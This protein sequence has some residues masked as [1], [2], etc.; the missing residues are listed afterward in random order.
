MLFVF[1]ETGRY[2]GGFESGALGDWLD[3]AFAV[4]LG[5]V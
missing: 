2:E 3:V 5:V 1:D 4:L